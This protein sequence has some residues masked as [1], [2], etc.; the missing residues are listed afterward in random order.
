MIKK[1]DILGMQVDNY[2][3]RESLLRLD[4]FMSSNVLNIIET[5]TM[6]QLISAAENTMIKD[7]LEQADLCII[8]DG[9][10]LA[11]TGNATLQRMKEIREQDFMNELIKRV[12]RNKKRVF[13]IANTREEVERAQEFFVSMNSKFT[14]EGNYALEE[15][16]GDFDIIVNELNVTTP[17]IIISILD[18]P[19]E[20]EFVLAHKDKINA[21]VWYGIG[22]SYYQKTGGIQVGET[23][24][25]LALRGRL[26]FSVSKYQNQ[27]KDRK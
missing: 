20:E 25:K 3:V 22:T 16:A 21:C 9:E 19:M 7:C 17:D 4:T 1:I 10:I 13:L 15:C 23:I 2:T 26:H 6:K 24:K 18:S 14:L 12:V 5:V 11:E 27:D 8:G